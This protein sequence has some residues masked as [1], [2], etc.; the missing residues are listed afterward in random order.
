AAPPAPARPAADGKPGPEPATAAAPA[1]ESVTRLCGAAARTAENMAASL[2]VPTA[3]SA[4]AIP[5]K[6]LAGNRIWSNNPLPPAPR[7]QGGGREGRV[8][9]PDRLRAGAGLARRPGDEPLLH[10]GRRQ[11]GRGRAPARQPGPSH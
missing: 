2:S 3:T 11:A 6:L 4:R 7:G 10:P 9:P 1:D 5:A 8:H